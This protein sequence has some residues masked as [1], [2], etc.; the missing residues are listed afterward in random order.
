M[1]ANALTLIFETVLFS[2]KCSS[3]LVSISTVSILPQIV[4]FTPFISGEFFTSCQNKRTNFFF[5]L[6]SFNDGN[7]GGPGGG[8]GGPTPPGGGGGGGGPPGIGGGGGI[9]NTGTPPWGWWC[10]SVSSVDAESRRSS[11]SFSNSVKL[12]SFTMSLRF[13]T[14]ILSHSSSFKRVA[15]SAA[16]LAASSSCLRRSSSCLLRSSS[17]RLASSSAAGS[18]L[19]SDGCFINL[20]FALSNNPSKSPSGTLDGPSFSS[21]T[22]GHPL[23]LF[24]ASETKFSTASVSIGFW[25]PSSLSPTDNNCCFR[26]WTESPTC[27]LGSLILRSDSSVDFC[28]P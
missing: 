21:S 20:A 12:K 9:P 1:T 27:K 19:S 8:G 7:F 18:G 4:L 23:N 11:S 14:I 17:W 24:T 2:N 6:A 22:S 26:S 28:C 5:G 3:F 16:F 10:A 15:S 13:R 25:S